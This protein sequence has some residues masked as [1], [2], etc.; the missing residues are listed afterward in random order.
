MDFAERERIIR[1]Y[2]DHV[3]AL[4]PDGNDRVS[5]M[6]EIARSA[7]M[8]D[9]EIAEVER[10]AQTYREHGSVH[11]RAGRW[12][13]AVEHLTVASALDPSNATILSELATAHNGRWRRDRDPADRDEARRLI[14]RYI[15]L[16]KTKASLAQVLKGLDAPESLT[17]WSEARSS[18]R[19]LR[20]V[21]VALVLIAVGGAVAAMVFIGNS[22]RTLMTK[23]T[24]DQERT[25]PVALA[26]ISGRPAAKLELE[27]SLLDPGSSTYSLKGR[28]VFE[29]DSSRAARRKRL[30]VNTVTI[31]LEAIDSSG[32]VVYASP[33]VTHSCPDLSGSVCFDYTAPYIVGLRE[34][35]LKG[36]GAS[37]VEVGGRRER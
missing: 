13:D 6:K 3:M 20:P 12:D 32:N 36:K 34:I 26:A 37:R 1:R 2:L 8:S 28:I 27:E 10:A 5:D 31:R 11:A 9:R 17:S 16:A 18:G 33:L 23:S 24:G 7:G 30:V 15:E 25:V 21:V 29:P 4:E 35:H 22:G 19:T 14:T